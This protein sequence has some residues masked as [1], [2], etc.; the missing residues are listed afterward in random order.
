MHLFNHKSEVGD[1]QH[2]LHST[3]R[4][5]VSGKGA[6]LPGADARLGN[7]FKMAE[8]TPVNKCLLYE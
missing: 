7:I 1:V 4:V 5:I 6:E 8:D 2:L 3:L